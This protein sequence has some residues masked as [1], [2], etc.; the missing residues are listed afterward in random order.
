MD[1]AGA[2]TVEY[3]L[4]AGR[5]RRDDYRRRPRRGKGTADGGEKDHLADLERAA[6]E[7]EGCEGFCG[8]AG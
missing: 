7:V 8:K 2:G 4:A 1:G 5:A 6:P 3:L